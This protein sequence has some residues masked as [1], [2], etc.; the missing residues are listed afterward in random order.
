LPIND[1][2]EIRRYNYIGVISSM[3]NSNVA[4]NIIQILA[5]IPEFLRKPMM[6][7]RIND[8]FTLEHEDRVEMIKSVIEVLPSMDM[9]IVARLFK[10]WLELLHEFGYE[11]RVSLFKIYAMLLADNPSILARINLEPLVGTFNSLQ[12]EIKSSIAA[13]IKQV[14]DELDADK[15]MLLI[16]S[17]PKYA[18]DAIGYN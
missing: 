18:L 2:R 11:K 13:D 14:I 9:S 8:F 6:R 1:S 3:Q 12:Q 7:N 4:G 5:S 17:L 16:K 10:T 15:R